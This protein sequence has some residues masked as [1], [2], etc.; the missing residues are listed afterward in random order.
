MPGPLPLANRA[1]IP[2]EKLRCYAL[3][4]DHPTGRHKAR[5]FGSA[6]GV[7]QAD[8]EWLRDGIAEAVLSAPIAT[9]SMSPFG[10]RCEVPILL[11]GLNGAT[12]E[13]TTAWIIETED[14][15]PRLTSVYVNIP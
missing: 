6:L 11:E 7:T 15:P 9:L 10:I 8:W 4:P 2:K 5:V 3:D 14:E 12:H 13:V 1:V